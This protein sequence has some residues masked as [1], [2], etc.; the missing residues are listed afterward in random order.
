MASGYERSPDYG[1]EDW[2]PAD[3]V[4]WLAIVAAV[5]IGIAVLLI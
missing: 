4:L 5:S 1:G 2:T 3:I